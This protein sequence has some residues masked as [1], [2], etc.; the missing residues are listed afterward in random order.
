[1]TVGFNDFV[2]PLF[3]IVSMRGHPPFFLAGSLE[4]IAC[5]NVYREPPFL[6]NGSGT[7]YICT[8]RHIPYQKMSYAL[9]TVTWDPIPPENI[10]TQTVLRYQLNPHRPPHLPPPPGR[11]ECVYRHG[12][13][14][15]EV[16]AE[17]VELSADVRRGE[18]MCAEGVH[19][20]CGVRVYAET[21]GVFAEFS[22]EGKEKYALIYSSVP[23]EREK[24]QA[25]FVAG[26]E[27]P[28]FIVDDVFIRWDSLGLVSLNEL[29]D[30]GA[31]HT[32]ST[33]DDVFDLELT[34]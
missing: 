3:E 7:R 5:W 6:S 14:L 24:M 32:K 9:S 10:D 2:T 30:L 13:Y 11:K 1:M 33:G 8:Y 31:L 4:R 12:L 22:C 20:Q 25:S 17:A 15:R 16:F 19:K 21:T 29:S 28:S 18:L 23:S 26:A 34:V 27:S